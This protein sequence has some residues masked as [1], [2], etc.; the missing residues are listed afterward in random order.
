MKNVVNTTR[1]TVALAA[2]ALTASALALTACSSGSPASAPQADQASDSLEVMSWW[3]SGSEHAALQVLYN[4]VTAAHSNVTVTDGTVAGGAGANVAVALAN[5]LQAGDPPDVWQT[6]V[7]APTKAYANAGQTADVSSV[8]SQ[9]GLGSALPQNILDAVTVNG[10]QY[11]VPTGAHRGNV[12]WFS[13][14]ALQKAGITPPGAGYTFDTFLA[15]LGKAK[16][17]G[18]VPLCLGAKDNFTSVELF[19]NNLLSVVGEQGWTDIGNDRFDWNG[20]QA[21]T[22]L[23]RFGQVLDYADPESGALTWDAAAQ[24]LAKGQCAFASMNDSFDG[25]LLAA[26]ARDGT[27]FGAVPYPGTENVFTAVIDTFVLS[28]QTANGQNG[29]AF[30]TAAADPT[31]TL[32]FNRI[33]G[34]VPVRTDVD[35]ASLSGYQQQAAQALRSQTVLMSIAH[36]ELGGSRFQ[37]G[38]YD[39]VAAYKTSRDQRS[40][41]SALETAVAGT[42]ILKP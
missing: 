36:G 16:S 4:A 11:G 35:V 42:T 12:L 34:S 38:V 14:A 23:Q 15:D 28:S 1:R 20:Q 32:E 37:E 30:L 26:G 5:R 17:A 18:V 21:G 22:A 39:G 9:T 29:L 3:T 25:E 40:F 41:V 6:F 31:T 24:K 8:Y 2:A 19:E 27:D 33:K 7:G 10:K 13:T